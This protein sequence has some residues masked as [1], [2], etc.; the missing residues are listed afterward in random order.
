[1]RLDNLARPESF[2][3]V[4]EVVGQEFLDEVVLPE[5]VR[6]GGGERLSAI[7]LHYAELGLLAVSERVIAS[8]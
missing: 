6:V 1:V 4:P 5:V 8:S 2:E 7:E 3:K